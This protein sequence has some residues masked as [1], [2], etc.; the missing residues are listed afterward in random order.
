VNNWEPAPG[1]S[2]TFYDAATKRECCYVYPDTKHS[3]AGWILFRHPEGQWVTWRKAT[4]DDLER[5][6][7]AVIEAHHAD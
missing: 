4:E 2:L 6:S 1:T 5:I 3:T 7:R